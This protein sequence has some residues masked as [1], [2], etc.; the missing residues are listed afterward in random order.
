MSN[1]TTQTER[2]TLEVF[3]PSQ[4]APLTTDIDAQ[5]DALAAAEAWNADGYAVRV[6]AGELLIKDMPAGNDE[7]G[8]ARFE[9]DLALIE[10]IDKLIE[11]AV[12]VRVTLDTTD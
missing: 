3:H 6:Y 5:N 10:D 9:R 4:S 2:Y 1:N 7:A 11:L 12:S 8:Q